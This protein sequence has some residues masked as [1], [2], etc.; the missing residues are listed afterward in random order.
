MFERAI[1][2]RDLNNQLINTFPNATFAA[3]S[4]GKNL[5][6]NISACC[7]GRRKTAFGFIWCY[8]KQ[9]DLPD[10]IWK[11]HPTLNISLSNKG[12]LENSKGRRTYGSS[13]KNG[14][15]NYMHQRRSYGIHRLI[16][17]TFFP[18]ISFEVVHHLNRNRSDNCL[19]NLKGCTQREN[20]QAY[21]D[22]IPKLY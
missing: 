18:E 1:E 13:A 16:Y 19:E 2:Q 21:H 3:K 6:V 14:Y 9:P 5:S 11:P 8:Q 4:I 20:I 22:L 10:E 17:E 7:R 12:R 15:K